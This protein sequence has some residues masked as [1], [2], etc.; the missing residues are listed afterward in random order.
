V[1]DEFKMRDIFF[2]D[3]NHGWAVGDDGAIIYTSDGGDEW[4]IVSAPI[5]AKLTDV[6]FL[7][8]RAGWA[9]G[10]GGAVLKYEPQG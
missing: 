7:N 6:L 2:T 9:V 1:K 5:P 3:R 10:L 8:N 4:I